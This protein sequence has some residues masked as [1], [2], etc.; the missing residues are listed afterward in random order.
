MYVAA[1]DAGAL[2]LALRAEE[3][4]TN[5]YGLI[6]GGVLSTLADVAIGMN[7]CRVGQVQ[8]DALTINLSLDFLG[9]CIP[10]DWIEAYVSLSKSHGHVRFGE[11]RLM[12][13]GR[14]VVRGSA[15]FYVK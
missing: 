3:H 12:V 15:V 8:V 1:G 13:G 2:T 5:R 10:G 6:H 4:H 7:L 14:L 9:S 11:C